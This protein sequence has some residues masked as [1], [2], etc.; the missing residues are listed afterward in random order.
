MATIDDLLHKPDSV[1]KTG[2]SGFI[3]V[4]CSNSVV[5]VRTSPDFIIEDMFAARFSVIDGK[6]DIRIT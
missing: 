6:V 4:S 5:P 1:E 3:T 2:F